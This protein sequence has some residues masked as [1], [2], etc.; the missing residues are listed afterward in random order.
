MDQASFKVG[1][2]KATRP[3]VP[4][5]KVL[6]FWLRRQPSYKTDWDNTLPLKES[7]LFLSGPVM[8]NLF[9]IFSL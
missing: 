5:L 8:V 9:K 7:L 6:A 4:D 3:V 2:G 1:G